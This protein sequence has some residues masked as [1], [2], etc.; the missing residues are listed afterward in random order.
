MQKL[1]FSRVCRPRTESGRVP[2]AGFQPRSSSLLF[3]RRL[4]KVLRL[5]GP[6]QQLPQML[7]RRRPST[8]RQGY[9]I[10]KGHSGGLRVTTGCLSAGTSYTI[11]VQEY[12][13]WRLTL[14]WISGTG[15]YQKWPCQKVSELPLSFDPNT[16]WSVFFS[17]SYSGLTIKYVRGADPVIKLLDDDETVI[18]VKYC[19]G[20]NITFYASITGKFVKEC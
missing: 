2:T 9:Q 1:A 4:V 13:L 6:H 10:S 19:F 8:R 17:F 16:R 7:Q 5:L 11:A 12:I 18:E 15:L 20:E 3:L 14:V